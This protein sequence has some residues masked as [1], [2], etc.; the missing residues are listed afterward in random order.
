MK[1]EI[2]LTASLYFWLLLIRIP[3]G[4]FVGAQGILIDGLI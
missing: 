1:T 3:I 4:T 2:D